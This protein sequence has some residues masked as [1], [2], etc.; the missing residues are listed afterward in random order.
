MQVVRTDGGASLPVVG[1][2]IEVAATATVVTAHGN[3]WPATE[4][5]AGEPAEKVLGGGCQLRNGLDITR[6][7]DQGHEDPCPAI[8]R[9]VRSVPEVVRDDPA[10]GQ[11]D[12]DAI[13]WRSRLLRLG[14]S[15][16][17][18]PGAIPEKLARG[19]ARCRASRER[20]SEPSRA[21]RRGEGRSRSA[22]SCLAM[23]VMP[24]P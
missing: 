9:G 21:R 18:L 1:A 2:A 5:T 15:A 20:R 17:S 14:S 8:E 16:V 12:L 19:R 22:L 6:G 24:Q 7:T 11:F 13:L 23:R 4:G 3:D 10:L